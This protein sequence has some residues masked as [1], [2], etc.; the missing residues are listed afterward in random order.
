MSGGDEPRWSERE[1]LRKERIPVARDGE[2]ID[3]FNWATVMQAARVRGHNPVHETLDTSIGAGDSRMDPD[4]VTPWLAE[5]LRAT[6]NVDPEEHGI[7]I[8]DPM[9]E[10][11]DVL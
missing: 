5:E 10:G 8:I 7:E 1:L 9:A 3:V 6:C 4:A 2:E 11:V